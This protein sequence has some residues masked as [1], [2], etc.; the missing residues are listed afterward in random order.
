MP[1]CR[2]LQL[3]Q[4]LLLEHLS[5]GAMRIRDCMD[6]LRERG[7]SERTVCKARSLL[8][9]ETAR[10]P[11]RTGAAYWS[12]AQ[13]AIAPARWHPPTVRACACGQKVHGRR[14]WCA[15]C[16]LAAGRQAALKYYR[17]K[18]LSAD[19]APIPTRL[20]LREVGLPSDVPSVSARLLS[21]ARRRVKQ[22]PDHHKEERA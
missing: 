15:E 20:E 14:K 10:I 4:N 21:G 8:P 19:T 18:R 16:K 7:L 2:K 11:W 1:P 17:R 13:G 22:K 6:I 9:I 3:A 5:Y 12:L